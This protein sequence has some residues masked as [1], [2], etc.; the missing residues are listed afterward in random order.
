MVVAGIA[1]AAAIVT[2]TYVAQIRW[3][4]NSCVKKLQL[5]TREVYTGVLACFARSTLPVHSWFTEL[6]ILTSSCFGGRANSLRNW[7][8]TKLQK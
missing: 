8:G 5:C 1:K 2:R 3:R 7:S 6:G 4:T